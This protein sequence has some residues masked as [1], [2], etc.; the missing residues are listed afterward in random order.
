MENMLCYTVRKPLLKNQE[1]ID[2]MKFLISYKSKL[3]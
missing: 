1:I 2:R 3:I